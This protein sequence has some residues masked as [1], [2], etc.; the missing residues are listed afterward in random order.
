MTKAK[1]IDELISM[2]VELEKVNKEERSFYV[3]CLDTT[4]KYTL[5][6]RVETVQLQKMETEDVD[7]Y[8][9]FTH[10]TEPN[11]ND[12]KLQEVYNKGCEPFRIV[13]KLI[14]NM[15]DVIGLAGAIAGAN[16]NI[17]LT[18]EIKN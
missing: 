7:A 6:T 2:K 5:A 13:D 1:S 10:V 18:K 3:S 4:F 8:A 14:P 11:L 17:N 15:R 16:N 12:P 9:V